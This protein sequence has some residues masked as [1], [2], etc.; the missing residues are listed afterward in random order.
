MWVSTSWRCAGE[1]THD[2]GVGVA[3]EGLLGRCNRCPTLRGPSVW[4]A[5]VVRVVVHARPLKAGFEEA[6]A[7]FL[8]SMLGV[9]G[10]LLA[11][12]ANDAPLSSTLRYLCEAA[13]D[14]L[15]AHRVVVCSGEGAER[16]V[17][18][19]AGGPLE[20]ASV[21]LVAEAAGPGG[22]PR[23]ELEFTW[24]DA[25][26]RP[27]AL[28]EVVA[29][30]FASMALIAL[31]RDAARSGQL[32]AVAREREELAGEIHDDPVQVMSAVSLQLQR[33][34]L[35]L[36]P[37]AE[38][39]L[40]ARARALNDAAIDRLRHV[41]FSLFPATLEEDG[42]AGAIESY[43]EAYLEP[44][45]LAWEVRGEIPRTLPL[46][47]T[48]LAFRLCRNALVNVVA[49][50]HASS[51]VVDVSSEGGVGVVV[52]DDGVGFDVAADSHGH[53][54]HLGIQHAVALARW[55]GGSYRTSSVLG[56]GTTVAIHLPLG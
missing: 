25:D 17:H 16:R 39:E 29:T 34:T 10:R 41:M 43:C 47:V 4:L 18:A 38:R 48:A 52:R 9:G 55:A 21:D 54:G 32:R 28:E 15:G 11:D 3:P 46:G 7:G 22:E 12:I 13:R 2:G 19:S 44:Q 31:E 24:P 53:P 35:R 20:A 45:G 33:L 56:V 23:A 27:S 36:P 14:L 42:L 51:V 5:T 37:G 26:H 50:A 40:A 8:R 30:R 1:D 6:S 49:H